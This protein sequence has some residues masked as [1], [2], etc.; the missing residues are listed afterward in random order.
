MNIII[1]FVLLRVASF[2]PFKY[3]VISYAPAILLNLPFVFPSYTSPF[4]K[5]ISDVIR[6]KTHAYVHLKGSPIYE[7]RRRVSNGLCANIYPDIVV[8]PKSTEDVSQIVQISRNYQ[9]PISVRSG[10]HSF[11]CQ[12]TKPGS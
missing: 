3:N 12:S 8:V 2:N 10:G 6:S 1:F 5:Q 4:Y 7:K 9:V 11:L